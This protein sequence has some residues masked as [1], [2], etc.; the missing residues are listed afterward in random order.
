ML[1]ISKTVKTLLLAGAILAPAIALALLGLRAYRA[2]TLLLRERYRQDQAAIVRLVA[3]RAS[4]TARKALEDL[5][6]RIRGHEPDALMEERF[7]TAHPLA[8]HIFLVRDGRLVYPATPSL[9]VERPLARNLP[10]GD[11]FHSQ[12]DVENYVNRLRESRRIDRLLALAVRAEQGGVFSEAR[13]Y[14]GLASRG[15]VELAAQALLGLARVQRRQA[16]EGEA[17]ESYRALRRRFEVQQDREGISYALLADAGRAELGDSRLLFRIHRRLLEGEYPTT[18][19]SRRFYLRWT[20]ERLTATGKDPV[21][22]ERLLRSTA[23]HFAAEQLGRKLLRHGVA[24]LQQVAPGQQAGSLLLD[25]RTL[26]VLRQREE[27]VIGYALDEELLRRR[28]A[29][30]EEKGRPGP[31]I[32][33][34]LQRVG[35]AHGLLRDRT[36]HASILPPPLSDWTLTAVRPST[37]P[38][39]QLEQ[40]EG[41]RRQGMVLGLILVLLV[42]LLLTYR[43][44][45]RES[46]LARLKSDFASNVS[47]E[48]KTPLTSIRMY[49]E[50]LEQGIAATVADRERYQRVIIRESERLG[51]LIA[52]VLDFSRIERGTR[53]YDLQAEDLAGL[54]R[55]ALE[56]FAR[57][58]EGERI[59]IQIHGD[60]DHAP[61][62]RADREAAIQSIL[63]LLSNAAKYSAGSPEIDV[64]LR[65]ER[66]EVG[67]EVRD[68][69]I[70]IPP[71]EQKRIFDDFYRAP[72][73]RKAGVEGTGLGL[74]LVRRHMNACGGR[75]EVR[76]A[77]GRGSAFTLWFTACEGASAPRKL[78]ESTD[79]PD[80][81]D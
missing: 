51:R 75:V 44:V 68:Q 45:R 48:L 18:A 11:R 61:P 12:L 38:M 49:A 63:N 5:E 74:A 27:V 42:G 28:V 62:I 76:S 69:G 64:E 53:R 34:V 24:E 71:T 80:P 41:L 13:R 59:R 78:E 40:R 8:K 22:A 77:P 43:G 30:H 33:L 46:E 57:L 66:G 16:R 17:A 35:E 20:V 58:S 81:G 39:D 4:E 52:N 70:G 67:V 1:S 37:D 79:G 60:G 23:R 2:E 65:H 32:E 36:L 47:H 73:A 19:E 26:L 72:G 10:F 56:T 6:E 25:R 29:S 55:E 50:M 14:Y 21:T 54:T 31:G 7:R 15:R 3:D 9:E